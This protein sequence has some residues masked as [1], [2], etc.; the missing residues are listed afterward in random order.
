MSG[1]R[2]VRTDRG[3]PSLL[4]GLWVRQRRYSEGDLVSLFRRGKSLG[5]LAGRGAGDEEADVHILETKRSLLT[6]FRFLPFGTSDLFERERV[7]RQLD[8]AMGG[9]EGRAEGR[10]D[11][12]S[13]TF[14][15]T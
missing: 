10:T 4:A 2:K 12:I 3:R 13:L 6:G 11:H 14:S 8:D 7:V 15:R 1:R 5:T 9:R